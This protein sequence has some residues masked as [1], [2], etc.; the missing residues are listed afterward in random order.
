MTFLTAFL[1]VATTVTTLTLQEPSYDY[2]QAKT[3]GYSY[4]GNLGKNHYEDHPSLRTSYLQPDGDG[5]Y[6]IEVV[7]DGFL[8]EQYSC[9]DWSVTDRFFLQDEKY[10]EPLAWGGICC[11]QEH[12]YL[13]V[14]TGD[15]H[16]IVVYSKDWKK[17]EIA[18]LSI[19]GNMLSMFNYGTPALCE[20]NGCL[21]G[22]FS[23][24]CDRKIYTNYTFIMQESNL[25]YIASELGE[26]ESRCQLIA[27][28]ATGMY[29]ASQCPTGNRGLLLTKSDPGE[30]A[31][32][33]EGITKN[34]FPFYAAGS[35]TTDTGASFG[36]MALSSKNVLIAGASCDQ[37]VGP[38]SPTNIILTVT[39]K[40]TAA[41]EVRKYTS[42]EQ[43]TVC[44]P[45]IVPL[46]EKD[47]FA[48][49]WDSDASGSFATS[50]VI[51]DG[52]G[53]FLTKTATV[54]GMR[55]SDCTPVVMDDGALLWYTTGT[56]TGQYSDEYSSPVFHRL[57][58]DVPGL[59]GDAD[60]N[61][62]ID[63]ADASRVLAYAASQGLS[64]KTPL[65]EDASK[66]AKALSN[67]DVNADSQINS[68]DVSYILVYTARAG[69]GQEPEWSS[70]IR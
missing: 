39:D 16:R 25:G 11:G 34:I 13:L 33:E 45:Y 47:R 27:A 17:R 22:N 41:T 23:T 51:V 38:D 19:N 48:L 62:E 70:I 36:G 66:E 24:Y 12:N 64:K 37:S 49:L 8:V 3:S 6:R 61:W 9:K 59:R 2:K 29:S 28:D 44:T 40:K 57:A 26:A 60:L 32:F 68:A 56:G 43:G 10:T 4:S 63:A 50:F 54:A 46:Q 53:N 5:V 52:E 35:D 15:T 7:K 67:V 69:L 20:A 65:Q 18:H 14:G 21:Y 1:A 58:L 30:A 42:L 31:Y 55:L